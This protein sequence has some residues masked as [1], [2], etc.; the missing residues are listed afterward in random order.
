MIAEI[1]AEWLCHLRH[2]RHK[3]IIIFMSF[4][5]SNRKWH[6]HSTKYVLSK[7]KHK[8]LKNITTKI[9]KKTRYLWFFGKKPRPGF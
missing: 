9:K 8:Y 5:L 4:V 2:K 1:I 7:N 3:Y 6:S